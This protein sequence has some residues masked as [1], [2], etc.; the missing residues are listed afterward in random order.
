M[1]GE[2]YHTWQ[3]IEVDDT[4]LWQMIIEA[5]FVRYFEIWGTEGL[6]WSLFRRALKLKDDSFRPHFNGVIGAY[7]ANK[8]LFKVKDKWFTS[9]LSS[10]HPKIK[11]LPQEGISAA[12]KIALSR[13]TG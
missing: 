4:S 7:N 6:T 8:V 12:K 10:I 3:K 5:A 11:R 2:S 9:S 1:L 13:K